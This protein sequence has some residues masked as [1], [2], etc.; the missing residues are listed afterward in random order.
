MEFSLQAIQAARE[1]IGGYVEETPLLRLPALDAYLGCQVYAKCECMQITGSFKLRGVAN[2]VLSLTPEEISRGFVAAS[3]GN[4]GRGLAYIAKK[5]G[6][7]VTIVMPDSA[8]KLKQEALRE[9]GAEIVLCDMAARFDV[10]D[11]VCREKHAT[12]VPPFNDERIM[13]GQGTAGLEI[14]EQQPDMDVVITPLAGGGL[15][16]GVATAV[17]GVSP[18]TRVYGA[19]PAARARYS[20]S[21]AA[22][23]RVTVENHPSVADALASLTPGEKCYPYVLQNTNGVAVVEDRFLLQGMKLLLT[24]GKLLAEPSSCIGMGAVLQ[25]LISVK[26]EENVCFLLSGGNVGLDQ[27]NALIENDFT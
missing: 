15:L 10:A 20:A 8:P 18:R 13:A 9:L 12:M 17:K 19:E 2:M 23:H 4:H 7:P 24:Q 14:M 22:G 21:I 6:V 5:L 27:L 25:G 3:S 16:S 1:R 11:R 26:P